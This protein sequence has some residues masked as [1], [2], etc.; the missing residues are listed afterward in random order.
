MKHTACPL[1]GT[2]G[3]QICGAMQ[4]SVYITQ[5]I[6]SVVLR[7]QLGLHPGVRVQSKSK[8]CT[9]SQ[10]QREEQDERA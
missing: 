7:K 1:S 2:V 10:W 5:A 4:I 6:G 3:K 8:C 9:G